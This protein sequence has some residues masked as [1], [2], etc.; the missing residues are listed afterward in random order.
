MRAE[1]HHPCSFQDL[2]MLP[3]LETGV[4]IMTSKY[5]TSVNLDEETSQIAKQLPNRS[6][7]FRECLR[8]WAT[9]QATDHMHPTE[10]PRCYPHSKMGVCP[11]CW[12][13]GIINSEDWKY[14]RQMCR[15]GHNMEEWAD[16]RIQTTGWSIPTEN[17]RVKAGVKRSFRGKIADRIRALF[18]S[19]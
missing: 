3:L 2:P 7:F 14:Y 1:I 5:M 11:L 12:P 17:V 9:A 15:E 19:G 6:A 13:N 4:E 10:S 18:R 8:R 16:E